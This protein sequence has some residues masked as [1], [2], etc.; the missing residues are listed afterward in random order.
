MKESMGQIIK[1]L[2]KERNFT[3]EELAE[4]LNITYQAVSRWENETGMPDISQIVPLANVLGVSTDVLFGMQ[5]TN[6]D[7]EIDRFIEKMEMKIYT[8]P[9]GEEY[10]EHRRKCCDEVQEELKTY[11]NNP[12]LLVYSLE[13]LVCLID[14]YYHLMPG[15]P[16]KEAKIKALE[17][18]CVRQANLILNYSN[19]AEYRS[20]ANSWMTEV[21]ET[22]EDYDKTKE[23]ANNL[24]NIDIFNDRYCRL[25]DIYRLS[26]HAKEAIPFHGVAIHNALK[27]LNQHLLRIGHCYHDIGKYEEAYVC[28]RFYPDLF[29]HMIGEREDEFS[30]FFSLNYAFCAKDCLD[31]N[32]PDEALDWLEKYVRYELLKEKNCH[33][34]TESSLPYLAGW[35]IICPDKSWPA[36]HNILNWLR[37]DCFDPIRDTDRFKA[38]VRKA[39]ESIKKQ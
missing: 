1:R 39:E 31:L 38:L 9:D 8:L 20:Y 32:R 36:G 7:E 19:N 15:S 28:H 29:D 23:Y 21:Y 13:H 2:R 24:P 12:K 30:C 25:G 14:L 34:A 6:D 18:E 11:T 3:Q 35:R 26:K 22:L 10:L 27:Y 17:K 16:K 33:A 4:Q 5:C 37:R